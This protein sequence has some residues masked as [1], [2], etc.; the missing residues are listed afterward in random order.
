MKKLQILITL[1]YFQQKMANSM[2]S[3]AGKLSPVEWHSFPSLW[4]VN[5][6]SWSRGK[7]VTLLFLLIFL[8][9]FFYEI[10]VNW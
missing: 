10:K 9:Q 5:A 7:H 6:M 3:T 8:F 2:R 4:S 1:F